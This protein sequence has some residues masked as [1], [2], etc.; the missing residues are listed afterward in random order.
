[1]VQRL[2]GWDGVPGGD[3]GAELTIDAANKL[4]IR[5]NY[6]AGQWIGGGLATLAI[7]G[8]S[9][10]NDIWLRGLLVVADAKCTYWYSNEPTSDV[11]KV[12]WT[13]IGTTVTGINAGMPPVLAESATVVV[14]NSTAAT[15]SMTGRVIAFAEHINASRTLWFYDTDL[16][17]V[18]ATKFTSASNGQT[19]LTAS[20]GVLP[21][22]QPSQTYSGGLRSD[23]IF[24]AVTTGLDTGEIFG[25]SDIDYNTVRISYNPA[26]IPMHPSLGA[27]QEASIVR[28]TAGIPATSMDGDTIARYMNGDPV[29]GGGYGSVVDEGLLGRKWYYYGLFVRYDMVNA[30]FKVGEASWLNPAVYGYQQRTWENFPEYYRR[31]DTGVWHDPGLMRR[32][33]NAIGYE[34]DLQRTW[35]STVGDV[36]DIDNIA[37][38]QLQTVGN[39]LGLTLTPAAVANGDRR[40]RALVGNLMALRKKKGTKDGV[41][42]YIAAQTGYP[43]RAYEGGNLL[44]RQQ[45]SEWPYGFTSQDGSSA[46]TA[47]NHPGWSAATTTVTGQLSRQAATGGEGSTFGAGNTHSMPDGSFYLRCTNNTGATSACTITYTHTPATIT[48]ALTPGLIAVVG[49]HKYRFSGTFKAN[50]ATNL[51]C[52]VDWFTETGASAG[53][54]GTHNAFLAAG[55]AWL[56][57]VTNEFTAP[58]GACFARVRISSATLLPNTTGHINLFKPMFVDSAWRPEGVPALSGA[59][60]NAPLSSAVSGDLNS[61]VHQDYYEAPRQ[62]NINVYPNRSNMA[63][64]SDFILPSPVWVSSDAPTYGQVPIVY[65][66][67]TDINDAEVG[68]SESSYADLAAGL[69]PLVTG[70]PTIT[71]R[72]CDAVDARDQGGH[73]VKLLAVPPVLRG[74]RPR[75]DVGGDRRLLDH[76]GHEDDDD[77]PVVQGRSVQ[78]DHHPQRPA[79]RRADPYGLAGVHADDGGGALRVCQ[80][81]AAGWRPLRTAGASAQ[82]HHA[83][84]PQ[85]HLGT[86]RGLRLPRSVLQRV[87]RRRRPRRLLLRLRPWLRRCAQPAPLPVGVL[88][89]VQAAGLRRRR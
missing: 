37:A 46:L 89:A 14:G 33:C 27:F 76:A 78:P 61:Y 79:D 75:W 48:S 87:V 12:T 74:D 50:Q 1:M 41:E 60:V 8:L 86:D 84:Q 29:L 5:L 64:N 19:Y 63:I 13:Q 62:V 2:C 38:T 42:G 15:A 72:R 22:F 58:A 43:V 71:L 81:H 80:R 66:S 77:V 17:S 47:D 25:V 16:P 57:K 28:S 6:S 7:P 55:A 31:I 26:L 67:Y 39:A 65:S 9:T 21:V 45:H 34:Y 49:G 24:G 10:S 35:A 83:D 85:R 11:D 23:F 88:P 59:T 36:W 69:A 54:A 51:N 82:A 32:L 3:V 20:T 40:L 30:W 56:R 70:A 53:A 44:H 18:G 4:T 52:V 68:D 73:A